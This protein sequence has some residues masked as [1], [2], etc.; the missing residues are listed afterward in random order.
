MFLAPAL[1]VYTVVLILPL[2]ETLR[3][4]FFNTAEAGAGMTGGSAVASFVGIE[5]YIRLLTDPNW[6]GDFGRAFAN[7]V[8]F[9]I[10]HILV[11]NPVALLLAALLAVPKRTGRD[12]YRTV[13][14]MPT[15]LSFV[16]VGFMWKLILS[17][18]WGVSKELLSAIGL[19]GLYQ[20]WLGQPETALTTL[21]LISC[22]Q[23]IGLPMLLYYA[24][25]ISIPDELLEASE[26]DNI[27][28]VGQFF[29]IR[30]PLIWPTIGIVT[31]LTY[32]G[33]FNAFDLI[34][35]TQGPLAGPDGSTD[36]LGLFLF[37]TFFGQNLLPGDPFMG[38][39]VANIMVLIILAGMAAYLFLVQRRLVYHQL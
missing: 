17:P 8:Y 14:F 30:L 3:I 34:F 38:A 21:A 12:F 18:T 19:S 25:L 26:L 11:Q 16:I 2:F 22:W 35:V 27:T 37:R 15:M 29:L 23:A 13:F 10:F 4:S 5:N 20:P 39:T 33:N 28:G 9:F 24:A 32:T 36:L 6:A 31:I 1:L 7:N